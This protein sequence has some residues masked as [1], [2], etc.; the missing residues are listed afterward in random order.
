MTLRAHRDWKLGREK[1]EV[2]AILLQSGKLRGCLCWIEQETQAYID[3]SK[4]RRYRNN[5]FTG[6]K[7]K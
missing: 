3:F 6:I 7:E 4:D 5:K 1:W 2:N